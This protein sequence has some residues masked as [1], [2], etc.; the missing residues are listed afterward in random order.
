[1]EAIG[2]REII[3]EGIEG[4]VERVQSEHP[5]AHVVWDDEQ[6]TILDSDTG[7]IYWMADVLPVEFDEREIAEWV[8]ERRARANA[9]MAGLIAEKEAWLAKVAA[10]FD[11]A[12][13]RKQKYVE[14]LDTSFAPLLERLARMQLDGKKERSCRIGLLTLRFRKTRAWVDILDEELALEWAKANCPEAIRVREFILK[15]MLPTEMFVAAGCLT[16]GIEY[17]EGGEDKFII[18]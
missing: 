5:E 11:G 4:C 8:G 7:E 13:R 9:R 10:Q 2:I 17:H 15:W 6:K 16:S 1:M 14:H 12:I 3:P 18:E